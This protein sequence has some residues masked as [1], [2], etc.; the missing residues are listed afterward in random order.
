M[1]R[2]S[3]KTSFKKT[4]KACQKG[5]NKLDAPLKKLISFQN[6]TVMKLRL[7]TKTN[8]TRLTHK[9]G[10]MKLIKIKRIQM[11]KF[12]PLLINTWRRKNQASLEW[13]NARLRIILIQ[14]GLPQSNNTKTLK[15]YRRKTK[16]TP[17]LVSLRITWVHNRTTSNSWWTIWP[18]KT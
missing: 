17:I 18:T 6:K 2:H 5:N 1:L 7:L 15:S 10:L 12:K 9:C 16:R 8:Q 11:L 3:L 14:E 4:L 13:I